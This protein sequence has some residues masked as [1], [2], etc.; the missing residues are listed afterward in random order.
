MYTPGLR[1]VLGIAPV[2]LNQW[3]ALLGLALIL[4]ASV[5]L[6]KGIRRLGSR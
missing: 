6:Q 1:D 3:L 4:L 2:S 5:E